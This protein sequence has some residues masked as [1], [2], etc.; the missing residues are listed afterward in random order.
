MLTTVKIQ[1]LQKSYKFALR[2]FVNFHPIFL[3]NKIA[4]GFESY[5]IIERIWFQRIHYPVHNSSMFFSAFPNKYHKEWTSTRGRLLKTVSLFGE[6]VKYLVT[7]VYVAKHYSIYIM[8]KYVWRHLWTTHYNFKTAN[9][10][11]ATTIA[12]AT[13][14]SDFSVG[15]TCERTNIFSI[16]R[17]LQFHI[18]VCHFIFCFQDKL[19]NIIWF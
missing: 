13:E 9:T 10:W 17:T 3:I 14:I 19:N 6:G 11:F 12:H 16:K 7:T 5:S 4:H 2:S 8:L 15:I 1:K 18:L